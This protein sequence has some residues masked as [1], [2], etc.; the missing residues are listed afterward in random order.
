MAPDRQALVT[1]ATGYI[2][3][4]L[5][6]ALV[7]SGWRVLATGRRREAPPLP[8]G[9]EYYSVNLVRD[10]PWAFSG[11][12]DSVTHVFHLAG[13]SSSLS[14][15]AE[16]EQVNVLG[17]RRLLQAARPWPI[18][19]FVHM[20]STSVYGEEVE[21]PSPVPEDVER[22]PSRGYGKAKHEAELV[23]E[24]F[25]AA[26]MPTVVLRPVTVY[27]P[28]NVK[29][30]ASTILDV[31]VERY[32]GL[33]RI[34]VPATPIEQRL[35]HVDDVVAASIHL[36]TVDGAVGRAFNV[37]PPQYPS[38]HQVAAMVADSFFLPIELVDDPDAG[39]SHDARAETHARMV[40]A[41]MQPHILLSSERFRFL[42]K[43]NRNNR[44]AV[45][46]LL[47]TGFEFGR[48]DLPA[49]VKSTI[50]WYRDHRWIL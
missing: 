30:L 47:G 44:L 38:S 22:H 49:G 15:Q 14:D 28:G 13:A 1:G 45:D 12:M 42:R 2:A 4:H 16:M 24:E 11:L 34:A 5:I 50:D 40:E 43:A 41:G 9:V 27:G 39:L 23:V 3:S 32:A 18:E 36:A 25:A 8:E 46:A 6:P 37:V 29:L 19:R 7:A 20:S 33:D 31:A 26:G 35:V 21:L 48:T 17:T 10:D